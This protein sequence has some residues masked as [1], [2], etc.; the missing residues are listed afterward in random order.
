MIEGWSKPNRPIKDRSGHA[1]WSHYF[2]DGR[3]LC[4]RWTWFGHCDPEPVQRNEVFSTDC[5]SCR[6]RLAK[7][8]SKYV[9]GW[10]APDEDSCYHV[11]YFEDGLSLCSRFIQNRDARPDKKFRVRDSVEI[12]SYCSTVRENARRET[13]QS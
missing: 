9:D 11:H 5:T 12:C 6:N 1:R 3:S 8:R 13:N 10:L 4:R 7:L 2:I